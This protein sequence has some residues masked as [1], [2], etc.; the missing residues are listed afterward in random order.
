MPKS[1]QNNNQ[2]WSGYLYILIAVPLDMVITD[3]Q[4]PVGYTLGI[5]LI[6]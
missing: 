1:S 4:K 3:V 6:C 2:R 5:N